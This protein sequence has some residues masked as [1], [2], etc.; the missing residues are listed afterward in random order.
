MNQQQNSNLQAADTAPQHATIHTIHSIVGLPYRVRRTA[1]TYRICAA[2][3]S[4]RPASRSLS[5]ARSASWS[6]ARSWLVRTRTCAHRDER[7]TRRSRSGWR[8]MAGQA[9]GRKAAAAAVGS[10]CGGGSRQQSS[11]SSKCAAQCVPH[12]R[13]A[14]TSHSHRQLQAEAPHSRRSN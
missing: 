7:K 8:R 14:Q 10:G 12:H 5:T 6:R 9:T 3:P 2:S 1:G 11:S 13:H 4:A